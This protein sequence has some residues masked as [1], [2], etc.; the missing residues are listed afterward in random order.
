MSKPRAVAFIPA[1]SGSKRVADK[2]IR[3]LGDHPLLA[4][5]IAS[6]LESGLFDAVV[7]STDSDAYADIA[8]HYGAEVPFMRPAEFA[9]SQSPDIEW[10]EFTLKE[11]AKQGR[12]YDIF[13]ILRPTSPFRSAQTIRRAFAAFEAD[14]KADSLRAVEKVSQHPGKMWL[15]ADDRKRMKPLMP[16]KLNGV[17]FHSCQMAALPE[18]YVQNAS[19]EIAWSRVALEGRTIAGEALIPFVSVGFEGFD[20]NQPEDWWLA[21]HLLVSKQAQLPPVKTPA[22]AVAKKAAV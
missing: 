2:N 11:L 12:G 3:P 20:I 17:P 21:E 5:S 13:S 19:L 22:F 18:V 1:R 15:I 6:A 9:G 4:Y 14:P 10:V 16:E 8:R 7:V